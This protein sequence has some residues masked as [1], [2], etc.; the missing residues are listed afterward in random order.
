MTKTP[1]GAMRHKTGR[2]ENFSVGLLASKKLKPLVAAYYR[3]ARAA[4]DIADN[5]ALTV[6]QKLAALDRAE[7]A[8]YGQEETNNREETNHREEKNHLDNTQNSPEAAA[9][10]QLF[11]AENLD[12]RL[13]TDL[14]TAFRRDALNQQPEIWEQLTD[15]CNYSAV[16]VG[17]FM[18]AIHDE[19]S[20][21]YL[22]AASLCTALQ[23]VNHLQDLKYDAV[24]LRRFYLPK[25]M[26]ARHDAVPGDLYLNAATPGVKALILE[27]CGR[28]RGQMKDAS[29]LPRLVKS[30][31]LR[32]EIGVI[33]SLTNSMLKKL[34]KHDVI[35]RRI[36]L[37]RL[38]WLK[39]L[40][41]GLI[42]ALIKR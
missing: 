13:Y 24:T 21:T 18:L 14:L 15:Y 16:P 39:A 3:A 41:A 42:S 22:P 35:S 25:E 36:E 33:V 9:L 19:N 34:E 38:D 32:W 26:M 5:P 37:S 30:F 27:I 4:D 10:G 1:Q 8:F 7:A 6:E 31:R 11:R 20:S 28:I 40:G 12:S 17:R 2:D 29:A 23:L